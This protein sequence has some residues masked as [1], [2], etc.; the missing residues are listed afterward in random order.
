MER[1]PDV[2]VHVASCIAALRRVCQTVAVRVATA[3]SSVIQDH[4]RSGWFFNRHTRTAAPERPLV[5]IV[6]GAF[7]IGYV[8]L[9]KIV[10]RRLSLIDALLSSWRRRSRRPACSARSHH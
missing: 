9:F 5:N 3:K 2:L 8:E 10:N 1:A 7:A 6:A 4:P